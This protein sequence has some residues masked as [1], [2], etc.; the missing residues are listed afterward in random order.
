MVIEEHH[1]VDGC[2]QVTFEIIDWVGSQMSFHVKTDDAR[3]VYWDVSDDAAG[4][5]DAKE[6]TVTLDVI[7]NAESLEGLPRDSR[8][9]FGIQMTGDQGKVRAM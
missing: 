1:E 2:H 5:V 9:E 4:E 7:L 8:Y 6:W 3:F